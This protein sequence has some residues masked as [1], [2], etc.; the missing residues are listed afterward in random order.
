MHLPGSK[1]KSMSNKVSV[2]IAILCIIAFI[3]AM[4]ISGIAGQKELTP[5]NIYDSD[6]DEMSIEYDWAHDYYI[7]DIGEKQLIIPLSNTEII[8]SQDPGIMV[9]EYRRKATMIF[10]VNP[11]GECHE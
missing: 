5:I 1:G 2:M 8:V 4:V 3:S 10:Y 7:V 9:Y 6:F 11:Y